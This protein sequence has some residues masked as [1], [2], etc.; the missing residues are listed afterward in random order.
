MKRLRSGETFVVVNRQAGGGR[1]GRC[2][3]ELSRLLL[4]AL[5]PVESA[6]TEARGH[7]TVLVRD[8]VDRGA[9]LVIAVGG[10]GTLNEAVNGLLRDDGTIEPGIRLA[11]IAAGTGSDF[12][13][14][15]APGRDLRGAV[16]AIAGGKARKIDLG[17]VRFDARGGRRTRLFVNVASF[18]LSGAIDGIVEQ[19]RAT[20]LPGKAVFFLAALQAIAA[21]RFHRV[22]LTFDDAEQLETEIGLVAVANGRFFGGGMKIAPDA[23]PDDGLLDVVVLKRTS[24]PTLL[25]DLPLV[26]RGAH[27]NH[28]AVTIRRVRRLRAEPLDRADDAGVLLDLDGETPGLLPAEFD[29]LPSALTFVG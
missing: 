22:R 21:Y 26:Y 25:R 24:K 9:K 13:R 28:P 6:T 7:A 1:A 5:G 15:V 8:A 11:A 14:T 29:I 2:C 3:P 18:G 4:D 17:R 10:D 27:R 19:R 12:S 20:I 23:E 16:E